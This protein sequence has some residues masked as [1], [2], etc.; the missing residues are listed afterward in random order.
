MWHR[1][2]EITLT[3]DKADT[4]TGAATSAG[5]EEG[6]GPQAGPTTSPNS[7]TTT[8]TTTSKI[9]ATPPP[10]GRGIG[11]REED[12]HLSDLVSAWV[13]ANWP[14]DQIKRTFVETELEARLASYRLQAR[15]WRAAQISIW[16]LIALLGLLISVF[17]GFKTGHGFTLVAGA[18]VATLTTLTNASHPAK[19]A[20]GYLNAR[21]ALRDES[22]YLLN[23][24]STYQKLTNDQAYV[25]FTAAVH[26]II[27]TKRAQTSLD[28]LSP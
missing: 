3:D 12:S 6:A 7:G 20:D 21:L 19:Q 27:A 17:A 2:R 1:R 26:K 24:T 8:E 16:L 13:Q 23:H 9:P 28:A 4:V 10:S 14:Q 18:L 11:L 22:W 25:Q 15:C 5:G